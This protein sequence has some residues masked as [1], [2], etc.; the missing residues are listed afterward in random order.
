MEGPILFTDEELFTIEAKHNGQNVWILAQRVGKIPVA[1]RGVFRKQTPASDMVWARVMSDGKKTP[2]VF[3][4]KGGKINKETHL[5]MLADKLQLWIHQNY[6]GSIKFTFQRDGLKPWSQGHGL[7][8]F[9][10]PWGQGMY[11][12]LC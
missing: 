10:H 7:L 5:D 12:T 2:V 4:P 3:V 9:V 11:Q 1:V 6:L 8:H